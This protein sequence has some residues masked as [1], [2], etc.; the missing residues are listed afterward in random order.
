MTYQVLILLIIIVYSYTSQAFN[1]SVVYYHELPNNIV[2]GTLIENI[3]LKSKV[4]L[5]LKIASRQSNM[6][7]ISDSEKGKETRN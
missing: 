5:P 6:P 2:N 3:L 7:R 1:E 4:D